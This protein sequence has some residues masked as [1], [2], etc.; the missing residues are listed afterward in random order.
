MRLDI[1]KLSYDAKW[2]S[3][4]TGEIVD[5]PGQD[6]VFIK[7]KPFPFSKSNVQVRDGAIVLS[8]DEQ[9]RIFKECCE[10][11]QGI[12]GADDK[13]LP[14][15]NDVKQKI[16]DFRMGGISD[17]VIGKVWTFEQAKDDAEKNS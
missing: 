6:G 9:C 13:P 14:C 1:T 5:S 15:T 7:I 17:F 3:M 2:Y 8:G 11:W 12:V 4:Q 10:E 16:Y